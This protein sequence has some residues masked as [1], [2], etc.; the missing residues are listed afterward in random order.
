[1]GRSSCTRPGVLLLASAV[2]I[3]SISAAARVVRADDL[4][5]A[6]LPGGSW[7]AAVA[8]LESDVHGEGGVVPVVVWDAFGHRVACGRYQLVLDRIG[9]RAFIVGP[10]DPATAS[11][12][13]TLVH[14]AALFDESDQ[15]PR[16][17]PAGI[18]AVEVLHGGEAGGASSTAGS[19]LH[20]TIDVH[21]YIE[22]LE[23]GAHVY[24]S[25][26]RYALRP[27][28]ATIRV[29][30]RTDGWTLATTNSGTLTVEYDVVDTARGELVLHD[31]ATLTCGNRPTLPGALLPA[32]PPI[33][34]LGTTAA[35]AVGPSVSPVRSAA[36][37]DGRGLPI[38][39]FAS[40]LPSSTTVEGPTPWVR[41]RVSCTGGVPADQIV[42]ADR[43]SLAGMTELVATL[44]VDAASPGAA[45]Q[46]LRQRAAAVCADTITDL[47]IVPVQGELHVTAIAVRHVGNP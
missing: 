5:V 39:A 21:P 43:S 29:T 11:T 36:Q 6:T 47:A 20:C 18:S 32:A 33:R 30:A 22:D 42:I 34:V 26:G 38:A 44:S 23:H 24:L 2:C 9:A 19:T 1:M 15:I 45:Q 40:E 7:A 17:L 35:I 4:H 16:P 14:R 46:M 27:T 10:C 37:I 3:A 31:R 25:P 8:T 13:V 41:S 12:P 28:D